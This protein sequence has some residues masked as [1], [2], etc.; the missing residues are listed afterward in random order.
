MTIP[1]ARQSIAGEDIDAVVEI[2]KSDWLTQGPAIDRF[3]KALAEYC[4]VPYGVVFCN[5][6]AALHLACLTLGLG[7]GDRLWTTPNTFVASA[8]CGLYCGAE[9]D[10]VDI[11]PGTY[12]LSPAALEQKLEKASREGKLPKVLVPVHHSGQSCDM[13]GI[14]AVT[15]KYGVRI[16][17]DASHALGARYQGAMVGSCR[18]SE[19]TVFS[20]HPVKIVTTGEGGAILT[21][22]Q[23]LYE[24]LKLLRT[25]GITRNSALMS[26][27]PDGGWYYEQIDLGFN[28]RMTDI[29]AALG[30]SQLKKANEFVIRRQQIAGR[31]DQALAQLPLSVPFQSPDSLS[32]RHLYVIRLHQE[33]AR[34]TRR[35]VFDSL[36]SAG[37]HANVHYYPVHLQ[38]YY[39]KMGFKEGDFP[40][41]EK[42]YSEALSLPMY[43]GLSEADQETVIGKLHEILT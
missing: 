12:N 25:H 4:G 42:F 3:E 32:A 24:R 43:Y 8:N 7:P 27:E 37:I 41:A 35:H 9:V 11:D 13:A 33:K 16:V 30:T 38:P 6:T 31:Y 2:L 10:F 40:Q 18:N 20:F 39:R 19:M 23:D 29:Q 28:Y 14:R 5:A 34:Q 21:K 26:H 17:E 36:R 1:Y 22:N 15:E